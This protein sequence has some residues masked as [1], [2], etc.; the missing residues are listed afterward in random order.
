MDNFSSSTIVWMVLAL[1][2]DAIHYSCANWSKRSGE[3]RL[4][5]QEAISQTWY[6]ARTG[7]GDP[8][9][10]LVSGSISI[11]SFWIPLSQPDY[12][13]AQPLRKSVGGRVYG[14]VATSPHNAWMKRPKSSPTC[15]SS[16]KRRSPGNLWT[17]YR[18]LII[19]SLGL[20]E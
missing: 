7:G 4:V 19:V 1:N 8:K 3:L 10:R 6:T 2:L 18:S 16:S 5:P 13:W 15:H 12:I 20:S 11:K 9:S 17:T 14:I